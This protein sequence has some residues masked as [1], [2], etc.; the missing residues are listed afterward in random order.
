MM[1]VV[2]GGGG[3]FWHSLG[4]V[5]LNS[6]GSICCTTNPQHI[7]PM[8]FEPNTGL[9]SASASALR[10]KLWPRIGLEH[11]ASFLPA[12]RC[13]SADISC[14]RRSSSS[15]SSSSVC[16]C[17]RHTPVLYRNG[18]TDRANFFAYRFLSKYATLCFREIRVSPKVRLLP[19]GTLSQTLDL[20]TILPHGTNRRRARYKQATASVCC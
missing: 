13:A 9:A 1:M 8:E 5:R 18:C 12:Q 16:A 17:V 14:R 19:S 7:E 3:K 20:E 15:S 10:P 6:I 11:L 4:V 2:V